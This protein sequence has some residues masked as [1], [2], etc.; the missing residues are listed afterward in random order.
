MRV[1]GDGK[2][3]DVFDCA[4]VPSV[5]PNGYVIESANSLM[6]RSWISEHLL[7]SSRDLLLDEDQ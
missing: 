4:I 5:Y 2:E 1:N 7:S 6:D 3:P